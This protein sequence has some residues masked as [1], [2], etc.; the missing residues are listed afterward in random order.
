MVE[1]A[2]DRPLPHSSVG[3]NSGSPSKITCLST[4]PQQAR[5]EL[6]FSGK[7]TQVTLLA[8]RIHSALTSSPW[9]CDLITS[10]VQS[11][12]ARVRKEARPRAN[13][14]LWEGAAIERKWCVRARLDGQGVLGGLHVGVG[15]SQGGGLWL[16]GQGHSQRALLRLLP[17]AHHC[18]QNQGRQRH[19]LHCAGTPQP[20]SPQPTRGNWA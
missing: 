8:P 5:S 6:S 18:T 7:G 16:A 19:G 13:P 14:A 11:P 1:P 17:K 12:S 2:K 10:L 9:S 3:V 4:T 20:C 15:G